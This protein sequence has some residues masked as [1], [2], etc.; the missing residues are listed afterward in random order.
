MTTGSTITATVSPL[1]PLTESSEEEEVE[2][3]E[4]VEEP[5]DEEEERR[6]ATGSEEFDISF[7]TFQEQQRQH[8]RVQYVSTSF[9][10]RDSDDRAVVSEGFVQVHQ[11]VNHQ[12]DVDAGVGGGSARYRHLEVPER[13]KDG[14]S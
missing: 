6:A 7:T 12:A 14:S 10:A 13:R 1:M 11:R 9:S 3:E 4:K 8:V 2:E 5:K